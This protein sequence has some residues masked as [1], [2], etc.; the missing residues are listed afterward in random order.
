MSFAWVGVLMGY[1]SEV[2]PWVSDLGKGRL[3]VSDLGF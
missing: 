3:R 1:V 2:L